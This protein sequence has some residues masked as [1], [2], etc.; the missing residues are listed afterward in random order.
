MAVERDQPVRAC[1]GKHLAQ[2]LR[3]QSLA[4]E[5]GLVLA[6]VGEVR[7]DQAHPGADALERVEEGKGREDGRVLGGIQAM[8]EQDVL[9]LAGFDVQYPHVAVPVREGLEL[10][11]RLQ[12][13]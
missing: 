6:R 10:Y 8:E 5:E 1:L 3:R 9:P 2:D 12:E 4:F 13:V 7:G 11:V